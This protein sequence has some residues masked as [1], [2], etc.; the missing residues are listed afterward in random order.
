MWIECR[1][2]L[3]EDMIT[4]YHGHVE[5]SHKNARGTGFRVATRDEESNARDHCRFCTPCPPLCMT[6]QIRQG[7]F[8]NRARESMAIIR[9]GRTSPSVKRPRSSALAR[10]IFK[11]QRKHPRYLDVLNSKAWR[12]ALLQLVR[13]LKV[14]HTQRV[15]VLAA[16]NL[17]LH[18]I[19]RLLDL[20][21]CME[22]IC[23]GVASSIES[24]P[25][26][27]MQQKVA[28]QLYEDG[29]TVVCR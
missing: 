18:D 2:V 13:L 15:Q 5:I 20:H 14:L 3:T 25:G 26:E 9:Q 22:S 17:E 8:R 27:M 21:G 19:L 23:G 7:E 4:S 12:Q 1:G 24:S 11:T 10:R 28:T 29:D 16:A 6:T